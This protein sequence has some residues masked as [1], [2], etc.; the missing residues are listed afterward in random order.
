[1]RAN[2][3]NS[4]N[5]DNG[6][7]FTGVTSSKAGRSGM[8]VV[9]SGGSGAGGYA[10]MSASVSS[11]GDRGLLSITSSSL[12]FSNG[13]AVKMVGGESLVSIGEDA[14]MSAGSSVG[15]SERV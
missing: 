11:D 7:V 1:M 4:V 5:G 3:G 13:G 14:I 12:S 2:S 8:I 15:G 10:L 6:N 9:S